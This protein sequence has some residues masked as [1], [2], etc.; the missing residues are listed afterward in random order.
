[1]NAWNQNIHGDRESTSWELF[2]GSPYNMND[3]P[4]IPI[5]TPV[6]YIP[7]DGSPAD[8]RDGI[9]LISDH[10]SR[11]TIIVWDPLTKQ[12]V[13]TREFAVLATIPADWERRRAPLITLNSSPLQPPEPV[14]LDNR[15][16]H[17]AIFDDTLTP[18]MDFPPISTFSHFDERD[19]NVIENDNQYQQQT[20]LSF[21]STH[22]HT[23]H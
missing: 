17:T 5:G 13:G 22:T 11:G 12:T 23:I 14:I 1:M 16:S 7:E 2:H 21:S 18:T 10:R 4:N 20:L 8:Q 9:A 19:N 6:G 15:F 3:M